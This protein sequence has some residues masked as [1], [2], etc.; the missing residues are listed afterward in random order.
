[1]SN[2]SQILQSISQ[3]I[4]GW[5]PVK[6]EVELLVQSLFRAS[7]LQANRLAAEDL[8]NLLAIIEKVIH[9]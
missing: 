3:I 8:H 7:T 4:N 6:A 9:I 2:T 1:M 5:N